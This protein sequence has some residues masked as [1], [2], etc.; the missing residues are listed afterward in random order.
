M[1]QFSIEF[2]GTGGTVTRARS[3]D[4][5]VEQRFLDWIWAAYP[6]IDNSDPENPVPADRTPANEAAAYREFVDGFV[7]GTWANVKRYE[8]TEAAKA[9]SDAVGDLPD[10][11]GSA[12][13]Y[14]F[15]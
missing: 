9:A 1:A 14:L 6:Q 4:A 15:C 10:T 12:D 2:Q 3:F 8:Q 5:A 13:S 7:R 11:S